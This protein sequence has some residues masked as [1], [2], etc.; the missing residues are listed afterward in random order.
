MPPMVPGN[1]AY[2]EGT[3]GA[4]MHTNWGWLYWHTTDNM[5]H[6]WWPGREFYNGQYSPTNESA[7]KWWNSDTGK[8][9]DTDPTDYLGGIGGG[10]AG[11]YTGTTHGEQGYFGS[12]G[13][14]YWNSLT[15]RWQEIKPEPLPILTLT[16]DNPAYYS[17][18]YD[19]EQCFATGYE[20]L[21]WHDSTLTWEDWNP[22]DYFMNG[23][24]GNTPSTMGKFYNEYTRSFQDTDPRLP[25]NGLYHGQ[26]DNNFGDTYWNELTQVWQGFDPANPPNFPAGTTDGEAGTGD[27]I[28][29]V[30]SSTIGGWVLPEHY[31][32]AQ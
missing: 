4:Q 9:Q 3:E 26:I 16:P 15:H 11:Y 27:L 28:G 1:P 13:F 6:D 2:Y 21:Y 17:G 20:T 8:F 10:D 14:L 22:W 18:S 32:P 19:G 12:T 25:A 30:W 7:G 29:L 5:W 31:T 24:I 23:Q